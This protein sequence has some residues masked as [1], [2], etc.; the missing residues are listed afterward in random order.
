MAE[1]VK[2]SRECVD[3]QGERRRL[4]S[5]PLDARIEHLRGVMVGRPYYGQEE[6]VYVNISRTPPPS[7]QMERGEYG[8][9]M[10]KLLLFMYLQNTPL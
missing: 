10:D 9:F 1:A 2:A 3:V 8:Q 7:V 5:S 4:I 6:I